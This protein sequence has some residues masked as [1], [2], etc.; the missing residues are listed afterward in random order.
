MHPRHCLLGLAAALILAIGGCS[1]PDP[2]PSTPTSAD[3]PLASVAVVPLSAIA[4]AR[5]DTTEVA[6]RASD[7][8]PRLRPAGAEGVVP[9]SVVIQ[10]AVEVVGAGLVGN[11]TEGTEVV[12]EPE[13]P[14][15]V[16]FT[17]PSTLEWTP[18]RALEPD[19]KYRVRLASVG[20][21]SGK[22][23]APHS[24]AWA[25]EFRTPRFRAGALSVR[26]LD[27][28]NGLVIV[29][30]DFTAPVDAPDVKTRVHFRL[31]DGRKVTPRSVFSAP[32]R[33]H[34]VL[35][36]FDD[37]AVR[38]GQQLDLEVDP[39]VPVAGLASHTL[40]LFSRSVEIVGEDLVSVIALHRR[41][42]PSGHYVEVV[43]DD[44]AADGYRRWWYDEVTGDWTRVSRR[45][46][47]EAA[48][49]AEAIRVEPAVAGM[50]VSPAAHGFRILGDFE[51]GSYTVSVDEGLT[52]EDGGRLRSSFS[53]PVVVPPRSPK[54]QFVAKGRYVPRRSWSGVALRHLNVGEVD[55]SI[56]TIPKD[57]WR[58]WLSGDSE[59]ADQRV[60]DLVAQS[61]IVLQGPPDDFATTTLDLTGM[62]AA[63]VPQGVYEVTVSAGGSA[64]VTRLLATDMNLLVKRGADGRTWAWAVGMEDNAPLRGVHMELIRPSGTVLAS[65]STD[66]SGGCVLT[67]EDDDVDPT[68]PI[69]LIASKGADVTYLR[70]ADLQLQAPDA[71][72]EGRPWT[73]GPKYQVATWTDRGVYRPGDVAHV[74]G[75]LR[76]SDDRAPGE[77]VPVRMRLSDPNGTTVLER[78]LEHDD[79]GVLSTD[80][81]FGDYATTG[82]WTASFRVADDVVGEAAFHVEEFVPERMRVD[83]TPLAKDVLAGS[84]IAVDVEAA[85]LFGGSAEGSPV[86]LSCELRADPFRPPQNA[87]FH[88]GLWHE[89]GPPATVDLGSATAEVGPDGAVRLSCPGL[90]HGGRLDGGGRVLARAAVFEAGSGRSSQATASARL[91][92]AEH[93]VGLESGTKEVG[94]GEPFSVAGVVVGW[95]G[96]LA[97]GGG[98][99]TV[100]LELF[101]L[102]EEYGLMVEP[103]TGRER[104]RRYLRRVADGKET[105]RA[106]EGK[107]ALTVTPT[108]DSA[109]YLVRATSGGATT[110]LKLDGKG[111]W[112]WW[113]GEE[114][115]VDAT[116]R[117][118]RPESVAIEAT[119]TARAGAPLDVTFTAPYPGRALVTMETDEVVTTTWVDVPRAGP[120]GVRLH[121]AASVPNVYVSVLVLKDPHLESAESLLTARAWGVTSVPLEP[122]D[123][124]RAVQLTVPEEV[125]PHDTLTVEVDAGPGTGVV[126]VA[127]VDVGIL[128]LTRFETPDPIRQLF[129]ARELAVESFETVGWTVLAPP[130]G[131]SSATG[132]GAGEA[133][134]GRIQMV[135]PVALWSGVVP[136]D[137]EGRATVELEVPQYRGALRVMAVAADGVRS[138]SADAEVLVRDP[139]VLQATTP[140][141]LTGGDRFALP[142]FV[143]NTTKTERDVTVELRVDE[144]DAGGAASSASPASFGGPVRPVVEVEGD[145]RRSVRLAPG[146]SGT[147][148]FEAV[149]ARPWGAA[150]FAVSATSGELR[151]HDSLNVPILSAGVMTRRTSKVELEDGTLDLAELL[152]GYEPM[153]ERTSVWVTS[154]PFGDAFDHL[155]W[156]IR[157]PYGC[158]EQ[159]TSSTRPLL[160]VRR[161]LDHVDPSIGGSA[162]VDAMVQHGIARVLSMQTASGG[163]SY[164]PG[165]TQPVSW[166]TAYG[167]HLL[168]DAREAGF[169]VPEEP[170]ERAV[171]WL[172]QALSGHHG[173]HRYAE[174]YAHYVLAK[175]GKGQ[176][177]RIEQLLATATSQ[178][179]SSG[180]SENEYLLR[181]ALYLTGDRRYE[182]ELRSPDVSPPSDERENSWR[183]YSDRRRRA[184][185]LDVMVDLF[186]RHE[187]TNA[188]ADVVG[189][190]MAQHGSGWYTTQEVAWSM[191]GLG[192][193]LAQ[194][195]DDFSVP[196][197]R[198]GGRTMTASAASADSHER[199]WHVARAG[200][201]DGAT[202]TV[203][204]VGEG[205]LFAVVSSEGVLEGVPMATGGSGLSVERVWNHADGRSIDERNLYAELGDLIF[206]TVTIRNVSGQRQ[207]NLALVDRFPAGWEVENPRLGRDH[208][209]DW[210]LNGDAW[211]LDHM[212][213]RDDRVE[214]FGSL[215]PGQQASF[216]YAVRATTAGEFTMPSAYAEAMYDPSLWARTDEEAVTVNAPWGGVADADLA[217]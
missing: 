99:R 21:P 55:V 195:R 22:V 172:D 80:L 68:A 183:F 81:D 42:G 37:S 13:V 120:T 163:L 145:A 168:I 41:E 67:P 148:V 39:G 75:V 127:A 102:V 17:S 71:A 196:E 158:I 18:R 51:R 205:R 72:T 111:R 113:W 174:P 97:T 57:N 74:A 206:T 93:W 105:V 128:Q 162:G 186:G 122:A 136:L 33:P 207:A 70:F 138:G 166:G 154:N 189:G 40:P 157:Y 117:P 91:H 16:R 133:G 164:W 161:V 141:F 149:A 28:D 109:G 1:Q 96:A 214:V 82:R 92:P 3:D 30:L 11:V 160:Y 114:T 100:E 23:E 64:D 103:R 132:G 198:L 7:L 98:S 188:L 69:A 202:L 58:F 86:E 121:P 135:E 79:F 169:D 153:T 24:R 43:C 194:G 47:P 170:L 48:S 199:S 176:P 14:G 213:V 131:M 44:H 34:V 197:L 144:L 61:K 150:T 167:V 32:H 65:C 25:T 50:S 59:A 76:G 165:A 4:T 53:A 106:R 125:R 192:K 184:L 8:N 78:S 180:R 83:A 90:D 15:V 88:Y 181:A 137:A 118:L 143:T 182:A 60:S 124:V 216:T 185:T 12:V 77:N 175:A 193:W 49:A 187:D 9:A 54:V 73:D 116:P 36:Q 191:S 156:L 134:L 2:L 211:A 112:W 101:R 139:L 107:F 215:G 119:G 203:D 155:A 46:L 147:V 84:A 126:T 5:A 52:T 110:E 27:E 200:E 56:R 159:T 201:Y 95:D 62:L 204:D 152:D 146:E 177:A 129:A 89:D 115:S 31:G 63:G 209:P 210:L 10:L 140:R 123:H 6:F 45:C 19:T 212:N 142:V 179:A 178:R 35:M 20:T 208:S 217:P 26:S 29:Q 171:A 173:D 94:A 104:W 151:S 66:G 108:Q 38:A 85:Y 190:A 130:A 87:G